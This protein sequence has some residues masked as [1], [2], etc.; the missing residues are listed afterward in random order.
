M[1]V[2]PTLNLFHGLRF[3]NKFR[4]YLSDAKRMKTEGAAVLLKE[5]CEFM[6]KVLSNY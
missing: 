2:K 5:A 1:L 6:R 3:C 4:Q